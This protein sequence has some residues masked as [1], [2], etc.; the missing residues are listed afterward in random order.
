MPARLSRMPE[1]A[2]VKVREIGRLDQPEIGAKACPDEHRYGF[3]E[4]FT[5]LRYGAVIDGLS[6]RFDPRGALFAFSGF[7]P[8]FCLDPD[9]RRRVAA[10]AYCLGCPPLDQAIGQFPAPLVN[11]QAG[12]LIQ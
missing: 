3:H 5:S 8:N 12:A 6:T 1:Q 9:G 2:A 11:R 10:V 4:P 7:R